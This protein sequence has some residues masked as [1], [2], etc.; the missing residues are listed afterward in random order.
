MCRQAILFLLLCPLFA[1]AAGRPNVVLILADDMGINDLGCYGRKDHHTPHLDRL[2]TQAMRFTS[3]YCAQ[4]ICSP[5]RAALLTG[6]APARLHLTTYL[7]GRPDTR[8]QKVLHPRIRMHLPLEEKTLARVLKDAGY[9]TA[10]I[11]KWHLGGKGFGPDRHGFD[12]VFA[13]RANTRPSA[14][15]GGKGEFGLTARAIQFIED[16]RSR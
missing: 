7:P 2:A 13:G 3:A 5:S 12:V 6:K 9:A 8:A 11:G 10:C 14:T 16:N 4:P 1:R 15:E